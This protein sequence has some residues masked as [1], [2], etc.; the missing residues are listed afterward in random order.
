[1][2]SKALHERGKTSLAILIAGSAIAVFRAHPLPLPASYI[3]QTSP[4][5]GRSVQSAP[6][7]VS[8]RTVT[9]NVT[10]EV[11]LA[12]PIKVIEGTTL[13]GLFEAVRPKP[14]AYIDH[15]D[16]SRTLEDGD[17]I[18]VPANL[19]AKSGPIL[20]TDDSILRV[21]VRSISR[22]ADRADE[23]SGAALIN[24]NQADAETLQSLPRIGPETARRI[25]EERDRHGP[26]KKK[27]DLLRIKGIGRKTFKWLAPLISVE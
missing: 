21:R 11:E 22:P 26:Y 14:T 13:K 1:M 25:I 23:K 24:I 8:I 3:H 5:A 4:D 20:L 12:G 18:H 17:Q 6:F 27:E 10:G 19:R 9:V 16:Y 2:N 15:S 7:D